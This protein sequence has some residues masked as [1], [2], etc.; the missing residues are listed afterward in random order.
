VVGETENK[1]TNEGMKCNGGKGKKVRVFISHRQ[2]MH[3]FQQKKRVSV[4]EQS[5]GVGFQN[6]GRSKKKSRGG[7][8]GE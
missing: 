5:G 1:H 6:G 4:H 7:G 8:V 3:R 2:P